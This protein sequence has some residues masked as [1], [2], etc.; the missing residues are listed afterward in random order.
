MLAPVSDHTRMQALL[1][2]YL[3][4]IV[5]VVMCGKNWKENSNIERHA[6]PAASQRMVGCWLGF[7]Q[8]MSQHAD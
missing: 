5:P 3:V 1:L 4:S 6:W 7:Q 8:A 2:I